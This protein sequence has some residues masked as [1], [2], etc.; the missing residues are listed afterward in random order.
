[1]Q[2]E[3]PLIEIIDASLHCNNH[4]C[5]THRDED[6]VSVVRRQG[7]QGS[8]EHILLGRRQVLAKQLPSLWRFGR[9]QEH[10]SAAISHRRRH[11]IG[12]FQ[13]ADQASASYLQT[14][15][16][17]QCLEVELSWPLWRHDVCAECLRAQDTSQPQ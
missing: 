3:Y 2:S 9:I 15:S 5:L 17:H 8:K 1:M 7:G 14:E 4:N 13:Q 11:P 10:S 16:C 12:S 6:L